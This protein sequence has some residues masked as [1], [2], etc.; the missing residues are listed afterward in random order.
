MAAV[1]ALN[2]F[3]PSPPFQ[4]F[5]C[6]HHPQMAIRAANRVGKTRHACFKAAKHMV[7]NPSSR[8]RFVG[9]NRAQGQDVSGLYLSQF[10]APD[11]HPK[12]YDLEGKGWNTSTIILRNGSI[13]QPKSY[14]DRPDTH[15]GTSLDGVVLDEPPPK[16]HF[17]ENQA[18]VIDRGG[19]FILTFTAVNR[20]VGWMRKI[21]EE[22][23]WPQVVVPFKRQNVPW[24]SQ[25]KYD[26][27]IAV[28]RSSPWQWAQRVEAEWEGVTEGRVYAGFTEENVVSRHPPG[29]VSIGLGIDH[30]SVAGH[31]AAVLIAWQGSKIWVIDEYVSSWG[32]EPHED[33]MEIMTMLTRNGLD[34]YDVI[35]AVGDTNL[36]GGFRC[37]DLIEDAI[38]DKLNR[39]TS[40][41]RIKNADKSPGSVD[42]GM[43]CLNHAASRGDLMVLE[44]CTHTLDSMRNWLGGRT[45]GTT[46]AKLS[47]MADAIR[48]ILA[49]ILRDVPIYSRLRLAQ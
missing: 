1:D 35:R 27:M 49:D 10:L 45:F 42:F 47:H 46:D 3:V 21:I 19:Q 5:V 32:T 6:T 7:A 38:R 13:C 28:F 33:A 17:A 18:R 8:W 41:F 15:A 11:L 29:E 12:C 39:K 22:Q 2:K 20:P 16:A 26:S 25:E 43:R 24:Y 23:N 37:N 36:S 44:G 14:D 48:Y 30:G 34:P 9:P 40:A 4:E 31:Q